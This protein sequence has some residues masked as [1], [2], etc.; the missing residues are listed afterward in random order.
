MI[1]HRILLKNGEVKQTMRT[2]ERK[3]FALLV[4][5][6]AVGGVAAGL[7][8]RKGVRDLLRERGMHGVELLK[9]RAVSLRLAAEELAKRTRDFVG[10]RLPGVTT[11]TEAE[12]QTYAEERREILGG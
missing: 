11:D 9:K 12:K 4:I 6:L 3:R 7:L 1:S 2:I 5:G 8:A 10:P